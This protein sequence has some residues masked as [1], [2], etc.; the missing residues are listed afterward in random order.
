MAHTGERAV[1]GRLS[2]RIEL[3]EE[4]EWEARHFGLTWHMVSR[5]T[6]MEPPRFFVDEQISGP[7]TSY[8]HRHEFHE[9]G[10]S[11]LMI[12]DWRHVAPV[13]LLADPVFLNAYVRRLLV[14]RNELMRREA[15]AALPLNSPQTPR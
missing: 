2:G 6:A 7:F 9:R 4:V 3:G 15:E 8:V 5:V 10:A 13:G 11:T 12:D 14:R 1:R